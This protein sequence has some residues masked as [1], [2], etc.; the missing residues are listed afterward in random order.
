MDHWLLYATVHTCTCSVVG[1]LLH[2]NVICREKLLCMCTRLCTCVLYCTCTMYVGNLVRA[3]ATFESYEAIE[4]LAFNTSMCFQVNN[5]VETVVSNGVHLCSFVHVLCV[6]YIYSYLRGL[7]VSVQKTLGKLLIFISPMV[8]TMARQCY[9]ISVVKCISCR[10][11][12]VI[13]ASFNVLLLEH[14]YMFVCELLLYVY[15]SCTF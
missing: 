6:L 5:T 4:C 12:P 13:Q 9:Q 1:Q 7:M 3:F 14:V 2:H 10:C 11:V 15:I 8:V